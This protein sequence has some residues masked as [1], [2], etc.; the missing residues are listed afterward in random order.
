MGESIRGGTI[1]IGVDDEGKVVGTTCGDES[2]QIWANEIKQN[3][4]PSVIPTV[5]PVHLKNKT[6]V[7]IRVDEFPV[8]PVAFKDR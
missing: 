4:S 1:L 6:V 3:T 2:L 5:E 7:S 8:K